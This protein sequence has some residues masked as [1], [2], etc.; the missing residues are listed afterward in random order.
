MV[1]VHPSLATR[2]LAAHPG[3]LV[4]LARLLEHASLDTT[5][6][7][8]QPTEEQLAQAVEELD[9]DAYV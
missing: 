8:T 9:V 3:D 6:I 1:G 2:Y 5:G 7:Y 4:G